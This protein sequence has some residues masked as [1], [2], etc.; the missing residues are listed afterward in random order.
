MELLEQDKN[1]LLRI[2]IHEAGH[3]ILSK[4]FGFTTSGISVLIFHKEGHIGAASFEPLRPLIKNMQD[5]ILYL[6]HRIQ[7]LYAGVLAES[8]DI[9]GQYDEVYAKNEWNN[10]GGQIDHAKIRELVHTLRNIKYPHTTDSENGQ[11][12]ITQI[13]NTLVESSGNLVTKKIKIIFQIG[14]L[15]KEKVTHY[16]M[17]YTLSE[18]ELIQLESL[19][20]YYNE[21][22]QN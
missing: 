14:E 21:E 20:E 11:Q 18:F 5:L 10:E 12:E 19:R 1:R 16:G 22:Y 13:D 8:I 4:E 3:Y 2:C 17:E 7:I 9:N 6:E 15:L